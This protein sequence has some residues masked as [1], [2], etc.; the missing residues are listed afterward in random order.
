MQEA[1]HLSLTRLRDERSPHTEVI[2]AFR[3]TAAEVEALMPV[4]VY[5]ADLVS[6]LRELGVCLGA[7]GYIATLCLGGKLLEIAVKH[8]MV[9]EELAFED[10]WMLGTLLE[11]LSEAGAYTD[12]GLGN[13][14]NIINASRIPAVHAKRGVPI[15]SERQ[16]LMVANAVID[17]V[18][19]LVLHP[20]RAAAAP[21]C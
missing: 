4:T 11:K 3:S 6:S 20:L 5:K 12:P 18:Q 15:P 21:R 13:L 16:A 9:T 17:I 14:A 1:L 19:R 2:E 10:Q 8:Y 7:G